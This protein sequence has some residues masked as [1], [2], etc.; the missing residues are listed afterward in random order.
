MLH[1]YVSNSFVFCCCVILFNEPTNQAEVKCPSCI[2][3][4]ILACSMGCQM[5]QYF[6]IRQD[7]IKTIKYYQHMEISSTQINISLLCR[8]LTREHIS[9]LSYHFHHNCE[10]ICKTSL[11]IF[12]CFF[13]EYVCK[14]LVRFL[15]PVHH[16]FPASW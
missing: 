15:F 3:S 16:I 5:G 6:K 12:S 2:I 8:F 9:I 4:R 13:K 14:F 7:L 11:M 1:Y 10:S